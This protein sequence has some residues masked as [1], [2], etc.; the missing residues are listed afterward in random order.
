M[1]TLVLLLAAA[2]LWAQPDVV[3]RIQSALELKAGGA[4]ADIG[5]GDSPDLSLEIVQAVG[6]SGSVVYVDVDAAAVERLGR[7]LKDVKNARVQVGKVDDPLLAPA[8]LDAALIVFAYHEMREH[9]AMLGKIFRALR[10][11]GRLAVIEASTDKFRGS[12]RE[13]QVKE[14]EISVKIVEKELKLAGFEVK[15]ESLREGDGVLRF[16]TVGLR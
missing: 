9:A 5:S 3:K 14:H 1:K 4:V 13:N 8:S 2:P 11:G 12:S 6:D 16:L 15:T 7:K 10:P